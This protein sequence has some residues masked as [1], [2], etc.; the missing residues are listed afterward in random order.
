MICIFIEGFFNEGEE[1]NI[2]L[3]ISDRV[4]DFLLVEKP[5]SVIQSKVFLYLKRASNKRMNDSHGWI[6]AELNFSSVSVIL[7]QYR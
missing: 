3:R 5:I 7:I 1:M 2:L 4:I 6:K